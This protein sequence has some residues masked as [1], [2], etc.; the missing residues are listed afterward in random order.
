M[1]FQDGDEAMTAEEQSLFPP[2]EIAALR[3][4]NTAFARHKGRVWAQQDDPVIA[5][6]VL[7]GIP[8]TLRGELFPRFWC[9]T[10]CTALKL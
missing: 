4:I 7:R 2:E 10:L 8:K 9:R 1:L 3:A 5:D 6:M